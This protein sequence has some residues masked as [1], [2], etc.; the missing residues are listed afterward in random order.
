M[1]EPDQ[2][3][4]KPLL[5]PFV[6]RSREIA[7]LRAGIAEALGGRTQIFILTGEAGIGKTRVAAEIGAQAA[8]HE[9]RVV[10]G[11]CY[12]AVGAP[13]YFP[14]TQ[15][16]RAL[17]D[18]LDVQRLCT[19]MP[20]IARLLG[21]TGASFSASSRQSQEED[22]E[23]SR[24][25]L[26]D[27]FATLLKDSAR[28]H[29]LFIVLDDLHEA[30]DTTW[31]MLQFAAREIH[32]AR[33][34]IVATYR[35][36]ELR[37]SD[38][39]VRAIS[40]LFRGGH[41]L[42]LSGLN[43]AEVAQVVASG[44]GR[45]ADRQ[46]I[47]T[48][49]RTTGGNPFFITEVIRAMNLAGVDFADSNAPRRDFPIPESA[50]VSIRR[51]LRT[52]EEPVRAMLSVAAALGS[53]CDGAV[54]ERVT[55]LG[56]E[57]LL[58]ALDRAISAGIL[59]VDGP[60]RYRFGHALIREVIYQDMRVT[61]RCELH[62]K[63]LS[64]LEDLHRGEIAM[65]L[66]QLA[67]HAV[68]A[69]PMGSSEKAIE[70]A[71]SAGEAAFQAFA[72]ERA[73]QHWQSALD[74]A[75]RGPSEAPRLAGIL[76][77][78]GDAYSITEFENPRGIE[79]I[80]RAAKIYES[81]AMPVQGA[82]LRARLGLL[83]AQR[84]PA[85]NIPRAMAQ[86]QQA[87]SVLR[88]HPDSKSQIW[89][90]TGLAQV[91]MQAHHTGE[92]LFASQRA[93]DIATRLG[94]RSLWIRAAAQHSDHLFS[95]GRLAEAAALC[96]DAWQRADRANDLDGAFDA[97]WSGSYHAFGLWDPRESQR[98]LLREIA[99]PRN[100]QANFQRRVLI[101]QLAFAHVL[102]GELARS[103]ELLAES[104]RAVVEGFI[105]LYTGEWDRAR[106]LL[107]ESREMMRATGSRDG[108]AVYSHFLGLVCLAMGDL[109][110]A[111]AM[112]QVTL[113][114]G[115]EAPSI[116]YAANAG[117]QA[118]LISILRGDVD[119]AR[120]QVAQC[121]EA[122]D[123]GEDFRG[124]T[125]RVALAE[126]MT[127]AAEGCSEVAEHKFAQ[128]LETLRRFE[129]PWDMAQAHH[130]WARALLH[131]GALSRASEQLD[132]AREIYQ[133]HGAGGVWLDKIDHARR[134]IRHDSSAASHGAPKF[135]PIEG[136]FNCEGDYWT[137]SLGGVEMRLRNTKGLVYLAHLVARPRQSIASNELARIGS[138]AT[139]K[140]ARG[141]FDGGT[142]NAIS[143][144]RTRVMVTKAIKS[145][146]RNIRLL[147]T[148]AGHSLATSI[149]TGYACVYEPDP[150]HPVSWRVSESS[151]ARNRVKPRGGHQP[152][153]SLN[154]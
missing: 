99:R 30:D 9:M 62:A 58:H 75:E 53:H 138:A 38:V 115:I 85:M 18:G 11:K 63:I 78:L 92:G 141:A 95:S 126:A 76:A 69:V 151:R 71:S 44:A 39:L 142:G 55:E 16:T 132:A 110:R 120:T 143:A 60:G 91:A 47:S 64:A 134:G 2:S 77:R 3:E 93:L 116:P 136:V 7:A 140:N 86:Y 131:D 152:G 33:L 57:E 80:E 54:L 128:A 25:R 124:T 19:R 52:L 148:P 35:D 105:L 102:S 100:S 73:A 10:W 103:K 28:L 43:E 112:N 27:S 8:A 66:D 108:E 72:Y 26:S 89:L 121:R 94:E 84:S 109:E 98:W 20:E 150:V 147:D 153:E 90:Y 82:H 113:T 59:A 97:A 42:P 23:R 61:V 101:Q 106:S 68:A 135:D 29:P 88:F 17:T 31:M 34:M 4:G 125:G 149:R 46:F 51:R 146:I 130:M 40:D 41:H 74:L 56:S 36:A 111:D 122:L 114:A 1:L 5:T 70:Y 14:M 48:L 13:P 12:E 50:R 6:G 117:A 127:A 139:R 15:V 123:C 83:L 65:H 133:R 144:E 49:H 79:C 118:A 107:D 129:L 87:E 24:F 145:A 81:I 119:R 104:P 37:S 22:A 137:I 32:D 67:F 21:G 154:K 96:D 45:V